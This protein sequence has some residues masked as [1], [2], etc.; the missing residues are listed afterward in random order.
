MFIIQQ[1]QRTNS[2]EL[3]P[4]HT[5]QN[6]T[7]G[8]RNFCTSKADYFRGETAAACRKYGKPLML[9][10]WMGEIICFN[11]EHDDSV[12]CY[13]CNMPTGTEIFV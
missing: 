5:D 7:F 13:F 8:L 2:C 10:C 1:L 11:R 9:H 4:S 12:L 6:V 3:F